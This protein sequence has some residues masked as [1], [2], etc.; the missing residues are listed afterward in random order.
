[1]PDIITLND[2]ITK[3]E[4]Q[5]Y[6]RKSARIKPSDIVKH[7]IAFANANGGV[8]AIGIE[9]DYKITGFNYNGSHSIN[10]F[11]SAPYS[12]YIGNLHYTTQL[13]PDSENEKDTPSIL[14]FQIDACVDQV[15]KS[16]DGKVYLRVGDKSKQ[17][18][19]D[20]IT[21][22]EYDKGARSFEDIL[23]TNSSLEDVDMNVLT[24]YMKQLHTS[25]SKEEVLDARGLYRNGHLTNAGVLLFAKNPTKFLPNARLRFIKYDG[26]KMQT[27]KQINIVKEMNFEGPIPKIITD[28]QT[29][30]SLQL[31]EFQHL[32][33][34]GQFRTIPEYPEFAWFEGIVNALTHCNYSLRGEHIRVSMY[35]DRLEIQSPG[36]LPNIITLDNMT[37]TRYS[38][39]PRIAR[40]LCEFGWVKELNEGVKRIFEE[41][42][43]SSL[44]AP[45]FTEP[46]QNSVLL[47]LENNIA[48][49]HLR[50]ESFGK[51]HLTES[52]LKIIQYLYTNHTITVS[53][54]S[55]LLNLSNHLARKNLKQL[56]EEGILCW[57]G[58]NE[59]DPTQ[60]YSLSK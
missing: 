58:A 17:L 52:Q 48:T 40:V 2:L 16:I 13:L 19:H 24:Q 32:E 1:M 45:I 14:I 43:S 34:N 30:V 37:T 44:K 47:T 8:L 42:Q 59:K 26:H 15:I 60:Y 29:A 20:Q 23:E 25:L 5:Y 41:M 7:L 21:Q 38:R 51:N 33:K 4:S 6:D 10:D 22:L 27:G 57:H 46:N 36:K 3:T 53:A 55:K 9:D 28:V 39:N 35:D 31:R 49:R 56:A 11:L 12:Q 50:I 54:A 18:N